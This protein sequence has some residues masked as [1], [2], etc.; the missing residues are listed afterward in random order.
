MGELD[1]GPVSTEAL[2]ALA[3]TGYGHFTT[4]R[5]QD[6][7][8]RGLSLHLARLVRDCRAVFGT[9]LD[10]EAVRERL[11]GAL[12]GRT[13]ALVA[14]VTVFDPALGLARPADGARPRILV[15]TREAPAL[16]PQP[17]RVT[18]VTYVRQCAGVKHTGLFESLYLRRRAQL[19]GWDDALFVSPGG[20]ISEGATWNTGFWDGERLLW[21]A[22]EQLPGVTREL[23][24]ATELPQA[25]RPLT[26]DQLPGLQAAFATNAAVGVRPLAA[27]GEV[28][29]P[30]DHPVLARLTAAYDRIAPEA[31]R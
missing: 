12:A 31:L 4:M 24:A 2:E 27:V 29:F 26:L 8:V 11:R 14:R 28:A 13:G 19:D 20:E 15:T 21:P 25:E 5:V 7:A 1:G 23:L 18:P 17:L 9:A 6:G 22:A 30:A 10:P 16:P 3:L